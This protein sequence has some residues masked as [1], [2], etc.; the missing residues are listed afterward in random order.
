MQRI[1]VVIIGLD[2]KNKAKSEGVFYIL[3]SAA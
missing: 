2:L 1:S 3:N